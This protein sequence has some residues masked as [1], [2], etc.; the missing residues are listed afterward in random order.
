MSQRTEPELTDTNA[1]LLRRLNTDMDACGYSHYEMLGACGRED[2]TRCAGESYSAYATDQPTVARATK[3]RPSSG[4]G[5]LMWYAAAAAAAAL[6]LIALPR[7]MG[8][9]IKGL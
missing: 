2:N 4:G 1:G 8:R 9:S 5:G 6:G 3:H 7:I